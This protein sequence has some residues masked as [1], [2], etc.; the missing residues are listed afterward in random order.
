MAN[1]LRDNTLQRPTRPISG[2][3]PRPGGSLGQI[4]RDSFFVFTITFGVAPNVFTVGTETF[5]LTLPIQSDAHFICVESMYDN[6]LQVNAVAGSP[7]LAPTLVG[8][9]A[10]V[11][12]TDTSAQR[13]LS[14]AQ[15]PVNSIFGTAQRPF[16]WPFTHLFR[17]NGGIGVLIT[18][19]AVAGAG[20]VIRLSFGGFKVPIGSVPELGL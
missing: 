9:G 18:G 10:I 11:L 5:N 19:T 14:S 17:A 2:A 3:Y 13:Q 4:T 1:P 6:S 12:L 7:N 20:Q 15:V 8:G 16:V